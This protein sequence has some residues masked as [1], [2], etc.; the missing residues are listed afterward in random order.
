MATEPLPSTS[1]RFTCG[2]CR[3][4]S[5]YP[6]T[7]IESANAAGS[8]RFNPPVHTAIGGAN[9]PE[10]ADNTIA[11]GKHPDVFSENLAEIIVRAAAP[12]VQMYETV[13]PALMLLGE[14]MV[15][16]AGGPDGDRLEPRP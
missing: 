3:F 4:F 14:K 15:G 6:G 16:E 1:P 8:C 13:G 12:V 2:T 10:V 11:C 7:I 9:W 5:Q